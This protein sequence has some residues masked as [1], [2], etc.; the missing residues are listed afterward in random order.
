[1]RTYTLGGRVLENRI[2]ELIILLVIVG[3][4]ATIITLAV[5]ASRRRNTTPPPVPPQQWQPPRPPG[6]HR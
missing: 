1:M 2:L 5:R 3:I 6:R 4:P